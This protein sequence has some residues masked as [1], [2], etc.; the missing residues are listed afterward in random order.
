MANAAGTRQ[1]FDDDGAEVR[2][3]LVG[4]GPADDVEHAAGR[5]WQNKLD[6]PC[7]VIERARTTRQKRQRGAGCCGT[8]KSAAGKHHDRPLWTYQEGVGQQP[9]ARTARAAKYKQ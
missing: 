5:E 9:A 8:Q 4:P 6:R 7:R 2:P 1:V 3:H